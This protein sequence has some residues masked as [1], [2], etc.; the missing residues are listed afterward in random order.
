MASSLNQISPVSE[1]EIQASQII[2]RLEE[3][4]ETNSALMEE[5][6]K[7]D[8]KS[9][10]LGTSQRGQSWKISQGFLQAKSKSIPQILNTLEDLIVYEDCNDSEDYDYPTTTSLAPLTDIAK[11]SLVIQSVASFGNTLDRSHLH[12][13]NNRIHNDTTR[14]ITHLFRCN[15]YNAFYHDEPLEGLIRLTRM[16]LHYKYPKYLEDGFES[17]VSSPPVIYCTMF[18][19]LGIVQHL[20]RQIGL[21]LGCVRAVPCCSSFGQQQKMDIPALEKMIEEDKASNKIPLLLLADAGT[22]VTGHVDNL[23]KLQDICN[24]HE[25]WMHLRGHSLATLAMTNSGS[26]PSKLADSLSLPLGTWLG[27]PVLPTVTLYRQLEANPGRTVGTARESTLPLIAGLITDHFQKRL[28]ALPIWF[29]LQ[30]FG[31]DEIQQ[32]IRNAFETSEIIWSKLEKYGSLRLIGQKPGGDTG[33]L[34]VKQL[35]NKPV[36]T[37]TLMFEV[38]AST[39]AFQFVPEDS[40]TEGE[41]TAKV[42]PYYDKLNSWLGQILQRDTPQ[43][44]VEMCELD[45]AGLVLR[46]CPLE[47][48]IPINSE[49]LEVFFNCLEQQLDI[50]SATVRLKST[51][52]ELVR[53]NPRLEL[54]EMEGWAGLG[55]VRYI[56]EL[57]DVPESEKGKEDLNKLNIELVNKLRSTDAAFSLGEGPDDLV[58]VRFGMVTGDT[59]MQELLSLVTAMGK[60][61]EESSKYLDI[62]VEIVKKGIETATMDLQK[63]NEERLWQEGILRHVPVFGSIVNWWSPKTKETGVKGRSLNLQAGV[64]E[65]T[66]NIYRY[67]MQ[68]QQ[69]VASPPGTKPPPQPLVQTTI[70]TDPSSRHSRSS[71]HSSQLSQK[72]T[73]FNKNVVTP[74][75]VV[76]E[77]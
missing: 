21:S 12:N 4:V 39:I 30:A 48:I 27:V 55:G 52:Q 18:S 19:S 71:S 26:L 45:Y 56:P 66:E 69:G 22:P 73:E 5:V 24:T 11:L 10:D 15:D 3:A 9:K 41:Y 44:N 36:T 68:L 76:S 2:E 32:R 49:N 35:V 47:A 72:S 77:T 74:E 60:E 25:L 50:L 20:C 28:V 61:V 13:L 14:W 67:H 33:S 42:P 58:C 34:C 17:L 7:A 16:L 40:T 59:D 23:M 29:T 57:T 51:F 46:I 31:K 64:V 54:V 62:M 37:P 70:V 53:S 38:T 8:G 75:N 6:D 65:S 1:I 63:E 43:L